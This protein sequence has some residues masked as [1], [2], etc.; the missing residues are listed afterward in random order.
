MIE[1]AD[2]EKWIEAV[3]NIFV[4]FEGRFDAYPI[5]RRWTEEWYSK[6]SFNILEDDI[7]RLHRLK[8][9]FDYS[10]FGID[11]ISFQE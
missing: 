10:T 5:S 3:H 11:K 8:E 4:I 7:E 9:N 2:F 6:G 1:S